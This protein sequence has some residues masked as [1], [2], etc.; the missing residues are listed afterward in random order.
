MKKW[1]LRILCLEVWKFGK[2]YFKM[3]SFDLEP[4]HSEIQWKYKET[5]MRLYTFQIC[6]CVW[7]LPD[8]CTSQFCFQ[9]K[10]EWRV[11]PNFPLGS[12]SHSKESLIPAYIHKSGI[13]VLL[14]LADLVLCLNGLVVG[15]CIWVQ[16]NLT[17]KVSSRISVTFKLSLKPATKIAGVINIQLRKTPFRLTKLKGIIHYIVCSIMTL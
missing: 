12:S 9:D 4:Q 16:T 6:T 17:G 14:F 10:T 15:F 5:N 7:M 1:R 11:P 3:Q 8:I 2:Y 13:Q